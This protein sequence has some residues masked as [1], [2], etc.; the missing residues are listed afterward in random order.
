CCQDG[1]KFNS[2]NRASYLFNSTIAGIE[3]ADA[4]LII[5]SN[6]RK[7]AAIINARIRKISADKGFPIG[8]I[9]AEIDLN[10]KINNLGKSP[11][12]LEE[13]ASG[14]NNFS[15]IL[16]KA[17][18]PAIIIGTEIFKRADSA[19]IMNVIYDLCNKYAVINNGWNGLNILHSAAS[20]VAGLDLGFVP[21]GKGK[22]IRGNVRLNEPDLGVAEWDA[23]DAD[24]DGMLDSWEL[25]NG[26]DPTD[27]GD[28]LIDTD[29][30]GLINIEEYIAGTDPNNIDSD[31]DDLPDGWE[32]DNQL[33]PAMNDAQADPD[34]DGLD[35]ID[36]FTYGT[37]PNS[38]DSDGDG[39]S[40]GDEINLYSTDPTDATSDSIPDTDQDGLVDAWEVQFFGDITI[41]DAQGDPDSDGLDNA[42]EQALGTSPNKS[43]TDGDH[44]P[45]KWEVD[46]GL[47]PLKSWFINAA[48]N[49]SSEAYD[50]PDGDGLDN[51]SEY[52]LGTNPKHP[53]TDGDD[54]P[55][56]WERDYSDPLVVDFDTSLDADG[57]G[58][59]TLAESL[60]GTDPN[61]ADSD[62]DGLPDA[63][64][65]LYGLDPLEGGADSFAGADGDPDFDGIINSAELAAGTDPSNSDSDG[66]GL[67]DGVEIS[68][69][70]SDPLLMDSDGD[71]L[72][73]GEEVFTYA[74][75]PL[76]AD[77]DGDGESDGD[78]ISN[79][80][81]P[82]D[83][84]SFAID[85]DG[86]GLPDAW[87]VLHFTDLISNN[88]SDDPDGDNLNNLGELAAGS[89]PNNA[90][91]DG[92]TL[93]DG[94]EIDNSLDPTD[95]LDAIGD[96]DED[97]L[98]NLAEFAAGTSADD[99]DSDD[100][101]LSDGDE[102]NVHG[103]DPLDPDSDGDDLPDGWEV[104]YGLDPL[105]DS[106]AAFDLDGDGLSNLQEFTL[107]SFP[108]NTDSD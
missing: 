68:T 40:D 4:L 88:S 94:W 60:A 42:S 74:T 62:E 70:G 25:A 34:G 63:W 32:V 35:N 8:Y 78:E 71:G 15:A 85:S 9:G 48:N 56:L 54:L 21:Y 97:G 104:R 61:N 72:S 100:D 30:D 108:D 84:L 91:S 2:D 102:V 67:S 20:R 7:E 19:E 80:S 73:D 6:P 50:D 12:I 76:K 93:P 26:L 87:E 92:D 65:V 38:V 37:D 14:K 59:D 105:D 27:T 1:A 23:A 69:Y 86:D 106:D 98:N 3:N 31:E 55:D 17:E 11:D 90:D 66:D 79:A 45:D 22:D 52:N 53:D 77:S 36:E 29:G 81:D 107:G 10:Y 5:G 51:L 13:I 101:G 44:L 75:D 28:A 82:L 103:T 58:L 41:A 89:D 49:I 57:D 99:D 24:S 46:N 33:N 39:E 83:T 96:P 43:D 18:R 64:E 16:E 95:G 47:D